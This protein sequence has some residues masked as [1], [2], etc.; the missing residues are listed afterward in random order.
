MVKVVR[1][2]RLEDFYISFNEIKSIDFSC[3]EYLFEIG[4][5]YWVRV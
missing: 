3:A 1:S 5:D 2:F 4:F